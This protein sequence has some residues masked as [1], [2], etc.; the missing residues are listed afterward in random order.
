MPRFRQI[1]C[2]Y[3]LRRAVDTALLGFAHIFSDASARDAPPLGRTDLHPSIPIL[4][5]ELARENY[6]RSE[7]TPSD[8]PEPTGNICDKRRPLSEIKGDYPYIDWA[9]V[10]DGPVD[11]VYE[12]G[13]ETFESFV[14]R[15]CE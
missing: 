6:G 15:G 5:N 4:G 9:L 8:A 10:N 2:G 7:Q 3:R 1:T 13:G 12:R 14:E 11:L